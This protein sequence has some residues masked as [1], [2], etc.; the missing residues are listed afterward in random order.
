MTLCLAS[1]NINFWVHHFHKSHRSRWISVS[2]LANIHH[3]LK[4]YS[5]FTTFYTHIFSSLVRLYVSDEIFRLSHS[6]DIHCPVVEE[7]PS[8]DRS[9]ELTQ[10]KREHSTYHF[11]QWPHKTTI[12]ILI[13]LSKALDPGPFRLI[14]L[15][16]STQ[17]LDMA[18]LLW[19]E[20]R[21]IL[22]RVTAVQAQ[23]YLER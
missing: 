1:L 12:P 8:K 13:L 4:F 11:F 21:T 17:I 9:Q 6:N 16:V 23:D 20:F 7:W 10:W 22:M 3:C 2:I 15:R 19:T 14:N 18:E 5:S